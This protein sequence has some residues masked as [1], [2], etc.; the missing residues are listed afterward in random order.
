MKV[1]KPYRDDKKISQPN[2]NTVTIGQLLILLL[3]TF[4]KNPIASCFFLR[5]S[6]VKP[7][8]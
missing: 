3:I 4:N 7:N 5:F 8:C 2:K 1:F 6:D